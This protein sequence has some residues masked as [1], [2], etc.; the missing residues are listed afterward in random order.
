MS[1]DPSSSNS[2]ILPQKRKRDGKK[3]VDQAK[4][5]LEL[6]VKND[7]VPKWSSKGLTQLLMKTYCMY[8][9]NEDG[10]VME[11]GNY[12]VC[13]VPID[14]KESKIENEASSCNNNESNQN[15][16]ASNSSNND[17]NNNNNNQRTSQHCNAVYKYIK[18]N[19]TKAINN[20]FE[21]CHSILF[22]EY[23]A[24][25]TRKTKTPLIELQHLTNIDLK[26]IPF[27][28]IKN[29]VSN[30]LAKGFCKHTRPFTTA[31]DS[32]IAEFGKYM[33]ELGAKYGVFATEIIKERV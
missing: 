27:D 20:H 18:A 8:P 25:S 10:S 1:A 16:N 21:K 3:V 19:G 29:K 24:Q 9:C 5:R 14:S 26:K 7:E 11:N 22:K 33:M 30:I 23:Q 12:V 4:M 17:T 31:E 2:P 28:E 13:R 32:W 15:N 6:A